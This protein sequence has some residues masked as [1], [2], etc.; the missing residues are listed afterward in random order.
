MNCL[1]EQNRFRKTIET[2]Y[3]EGAADAQMK[4]YGQVLSRFAE[5]FGAREPRI[6]R[7]P[8]R[9]EI[10]GNHTDHQHGQVLAAA[11]DL[12]AVAAAA[13]TG[14]G[15]ICVFS[16]GFG[17]IELDLGQPYTD[18]L[19][20]AETGTAAALVRG[21]A[22]ELKKQDWR[23][24]GF[25]AYV[26]SDVPEGS[27]LSSSA[28][29][30]V[31]IGVII[32]GLFHGGSIPS[33]TIAHAAQAAENNYYGKPCGLMD[34]MACAAGGLCRM[35]FRDPESPAVEKLVVDFR[36]LGYNIC[37]TNTRGSH[38]EHTDDYAAV[39]TELASAASVFGK[40][41]LEGVT[42]E[43][44]IGRAAAIRKAGGDRAFLRAMHVAAENDRVRRE[45][46]AL[47]RRDMA[48]FLDLVRQSGDSSYKLLQ[49]VHTSGDP[50]K[51]ELAVAL[52]VSEAVLGTG[53][54]ACRI[55]GGGFAGTI[56]AFVPLQKTDQY[57]TAMNELFGEGS[58]RT[59]RI[60][61]EG[62]MQLE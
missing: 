31:L 28:A 51:Q 17:K 26:T 15:K 55:H 13:P 25:C 43:D 47:K 3:G 40:D 46:E 48:A 6:F 44:V 45:T 38:A 52:A 57:I 41:V 10:G 36:E 24:G 42:S 27:G 60:C 14:D 4:R 30:E 50:R 2:I 18:E 22:E 58:C 1:M 19:K 61:P 21:V 5:E 49:N 11:I 9:T 54:S 34:Q 20:R 53:D 39:R 56:Q 59:V 16:E 35:D 62:G 23:A 8:G 33:E 29:F 12:D 7:A 37:I 32:S